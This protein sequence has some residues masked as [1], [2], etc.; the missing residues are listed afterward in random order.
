MYTLRV[1]VCV[2][3]SVSVCVHGTYCVCTHEIAERLCTSHLCHVLVDTAVFSAQ[4]L[5]FHSECQR[6]A[7]LDMKGSGG[8]RDLPMAAKIEAPL[9]FL[10]VISPFKSQGRHAA[11]MHCLTISDVMWGMFR[12]K[13]M[14]VC[15]CVC[16]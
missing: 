16:V 10:F 8:G 9:H 5:P 2:C 13:V 7:V 15:V 11:M 14:S 3:V 4:V 12:R 1:C 6:S